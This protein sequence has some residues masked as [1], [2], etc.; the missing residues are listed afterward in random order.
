[1]LL[2]GDGDGDGGG[3]GGGVVGVAG[4]F[5][6]DGDPPKPLLHR[7]GETGFEK[8]SGSRSKLTDEHFYVPALI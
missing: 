4:V 6:G 7:Y 1:V 8:S 3:G 5:G 2:D